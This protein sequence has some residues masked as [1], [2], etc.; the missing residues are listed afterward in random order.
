MKPVIDEALRAVPWRSLVWCWVAGCGFLAVVWVL[1]DVW[2]V[3][4]A[5]LMVDPGAVSRSAWYV[6]AVSH[7]G[8]L[9]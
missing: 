3:S 5:L 2:S 7:V 1:A 6:G 9:L 4:F 8:V